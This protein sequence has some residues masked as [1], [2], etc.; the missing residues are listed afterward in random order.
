MGPGLPCQ[1]T[2]NSRAIVCVGRAEQRRHFY[3]DLAG[4]PKLKEVE[5][6]TWKAFEGVN[7]P[8]RIRA[9]VTQILVDKESGE[10]LPYSEIYSATF[11][12]NSVNTAIPKEL[13]ER[14][15]VATMQ[16]VQ[17]LLNRSSVMDVDSK[18]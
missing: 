1:S 2:G 12:W 15:H 17:A 11:D 14:E 13:L 7:V 16:D 5:D 4:K 6:Y 18:P 10:H 8:T 9:E 3:I